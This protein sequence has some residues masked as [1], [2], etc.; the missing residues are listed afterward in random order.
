[1]FSPKEFHVLRLLNAPPLVA[2]HVAQNASF[3]SLTGV[4]NMVKA[5]LKGKKVSPTTHVPVMIGPFRGAGLRIICGGTVAALAQVIEE[6]NFSS[7]SLSLLMP[8]I[9]LLVRCF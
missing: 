8:N 2:V 1:M 7:K 5:G 6:N 9:R 3:P 4:R